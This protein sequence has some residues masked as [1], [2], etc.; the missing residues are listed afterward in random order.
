MKRSD[1]ACPGAIGI[2]HAL[3]ATPASRQRAAPQA[4]LRF[5]PL[6]DGC[7]TCAYLTED[8]NDPG[9]SIDCVFET[10]HE[11]PEFLSTTRESVDVQRSTCGVLASDQRDRRPISPLRL[12]PHP[13]SVCREVKRLVGRAVLWRRRYANGNR[14]PRRGTAVRLGERVAANR[15]T[16]PF[17]DP[18]RRRRRR[19]EQRHELVPTAI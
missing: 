5:E 9:I 10:A 16:Q 1:Q 11:G 2:T 6:N 14:D 7:G 13:R 15:R 3:L 18:V 17:G 4:H 8:D 12:Q 19:T